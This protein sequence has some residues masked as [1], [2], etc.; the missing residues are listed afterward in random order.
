MEN[1]RIKVKIGD[2][3]FDA[4]GKPEDIKAQYEAFL[5]IVASVPKV[6]PP[7]AAAVAPPALPV[8]GQ[9]NHPEQ[10]LPA[11][12]MDRVFRRGD[13]LSLAALP[14][15]EQGPQDAMIALLYGYLKIQSESTVTGTSLM[16][17]AKISGVDLGKSDRVDRV[18]SGLIPD[19]I[20]AAGV[21][22]AKRYQLNNRGLAR[23]ETV[24][25]AIL[26]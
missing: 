21:K 22:K 8:P 6:A 5:A 2:A 24:I 3:E 13:T 17:S 16:K 20:L 25:K 12:I 19:Y 7:P 4:E 14:S 18:I 11:E 10:G 1:H 26:Q 23:A 15:G 9:P